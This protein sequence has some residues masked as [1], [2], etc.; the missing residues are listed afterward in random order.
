M[1]V[2]YVVLGATAGVLLV[3]RLTR[4]AEAWTPE[5]MTH[6]IGSAIS[7]FVDEIRTGMAEREA[8]LRSALGIDEGNG[9]RHE[10]A[11]D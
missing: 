2:F 7:G 10:T 9:V 1:R 3:R 8:D 6:R 4:A 5:G 11:V